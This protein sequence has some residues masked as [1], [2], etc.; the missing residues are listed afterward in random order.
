MYDNT[1]GIPIDIH[2]TGEEKKNN[3]CIGIKTNIR[4]SKISIEDALFYRFKYIF[5]DNN[6][7]FQ[8]ITSSINF[9]KL[10]E[11]P[12]NE[13]KIFTRSAIS[14]KEKLSPLELYKDIFLQIKEYYYEKNTNNSEQI[15][16]LVDGFYNNTNFNHNGTVETA[17]NLGM[18]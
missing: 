2:F 14:K 7:T 13:P 16:I 4:K 3:E 10:T 9:D 11:N 17:M 18:E 8:S 12:S 5:S 6:N 1:N 15:I